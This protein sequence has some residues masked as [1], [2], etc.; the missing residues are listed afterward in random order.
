MAAQHLVRSHNNQRFSVL[1]SNAKREFCQ[2]ALHKDKTAQL[3]AVESETIYASFFLRSKHSE[4]TV[5]EVKAFEGLGWPCEL[6]RAVQA[7]SSAQTSQSWPS[8]SSIGKNRW[9]RDSAP[10]LGVRGAKARTAEPR[11]PQLN[12]R[13]CPVLSG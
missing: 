1:V 12:L 9:P 7:T 13:P 5:R 11:D 4:G 8:T 10:Q 6:P 3:S 2:G